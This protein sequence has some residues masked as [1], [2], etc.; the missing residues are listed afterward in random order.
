MPRLLPVFAAL[1]LFAGGCG[2][3]ASVADDAAVPPA[4]SDPWVLDAVAST[5]DRPA[6]VIVAHPGRWTGMAAPLAAAATLLPDAFAAPLAAAAEPGQWLQATLRALEVDAPALTVDGWDRGRPLVLALADVPL[7]GPVGALAAGSSLLRG[8]LPGLRHQVILPA[9]D[10]AALVASLARALAGLGPELPGVATGGFARDLGSGDLI[11]AAPEADR[12]RLVVVR[13]G[14]TAAARPAPDAAARPAPDAATRPAADALARPGAATRTAG[15]VALAGDDALA[16]LV[17]PQRLPA[18]QVWS[19]GRAALAGAA[20]LGPGAASLARRAALQ[21]LV[22]CEAAL[23]DEAPEVDD[24]TVGARVEG[25]ALRVRAVAGLTPRGQA[26][27]AAGTAVAAPLLALRRDAPLAGWLR[28]DVEAARATLGAPASR[29]PVDERGVP[30]A[31]E[32]VPLLLAPAAPLGGPERTFRSMLATLPPGTPV[33]ARPR[34]QALQFAVT[35][36]SAGGPRGAWTELRADPPDVA[37]ARAGAEGLA[38]W[39]DAPAQVHADGGRLLVGLGVDPREVFGAPAPADG[40]LELRAD[41]DAAAPTLR[42]RLPAL[43]GALRPY[44]RLAL[45]ADLAGRALTADLALG[46]VAPRRPDLGAVTWTSPA[47]AGGGACGVDYARALAALLRRTV[48][49]TSL[50][51]LDIP[52]PSTLSVADARGLLATLD[53][54]LACPELAG[55]APALRRVAAAAIA[56]AFV[57]QWRPADAA[58]VLAGPCDAGD[59]EACARRSAL[60]DAVA[61]ALPAVTPACPESYPAHALAVAPGGLAL[62]GARLDASALAAELTRRLADGPL[63]LAIAADAGMTLAELR[64]VLAGLQGHAGL[65]LYVAVR[66]GAAVVHVPIGPPGLAGGPQTPD[67]DGPAPQVLRVDEAD[68][69]ADAA[70]IDAPLRVVAGEGTPWR[71]IAG[72]L[73]RG[74]GGARLVE[75]T[76]VVAAPAAARVPDGRLDRDIIRRIVRAHINEVRH[77]YNQALARDPNARGRVAVRFTIASDGK[78]A[79]ADVDESTLRDP[80]VAPCIAGAVRRWTFPRPEGGGAVVVTY[81]FVLEPG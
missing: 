50:D 44:R 63:D 37:A 46:D 36:L 12:V 77:C 35:E 9:S 69:L 42:A 79:D 57:E 47:R 68:P 67:A 27:A 6:V 45:R 74:C 61:P 33:P 54:P 49:S 48:G 25:E 66:S 80:A 23:G 78:V 19:E 7:D 1:A 13:G 34:V 60:Q 39:F 21:A 16:V 81:P 70:P 8:T 24:W 15:V 10:P 32:C 38:A 75:A 53:A 31:F 22:G 58:A 55:A 17:R 51:D 30:L 26:A 4:A 64:P 65:R 43:A 56:D 59:A 2:R 62:D 41:L 72:G 18:L 71:A 11:A 28:F 73:A 52:D 3:P 5:G 20:G 76:Q 40:L 29:V 14:Q